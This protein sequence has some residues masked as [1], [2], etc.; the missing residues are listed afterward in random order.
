MASQITNL[1]IVYSTVYSGADQRKHQSS[2]SL[3]FVRRI[4]RWPVNSP[5]KW[6]VTGKM[7]PLDDV[8]MSLASNDLGYGYCD[9]TTNIIQNG[10][11]DLAK[12]RGT[13][14]VQAQ[15]VFTR[16][17]VCRREDIPL[18]KLYPATGVA[19]FPLN[20]KHCV[21][22]E[23]SWHGNSFNITSPL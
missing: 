15:A 11:R 5:H 14:C 12:S 3:A 9:Q 8:I 18:T 17:D 2:A 13:S 20:K 7:F 23:I 10:T 19:H 6:S 1:T 21:W 16:R 22:H 4:H